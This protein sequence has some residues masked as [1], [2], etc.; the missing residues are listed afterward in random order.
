M[1]NEDAQHRGQRYKVHKQQPRVSTLCFGTVLVSVSFGIVH[2]TWW[3]L[4][5]HWLLLCVWHRG[6]C[7]F[8]I[9]NIRK[10]YMVCLLSGQLQ[11]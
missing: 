2:N 8:W 1:Q 6:A 3:P 10:D 5:V 4:L 7:K 9:G 11:S